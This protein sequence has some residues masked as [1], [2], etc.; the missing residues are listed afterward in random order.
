M[1]TELGKI[2]IL[3]GAVLLCLGVLLTW[4]PASRLGKLPGDLN[5]SILG[6]R[7]YLPLATSVLLS[8][9]LTLLFWLGAWMRK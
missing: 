8:V 5:F 6:V 2:L 3:L 7:V 1:S 4:L 9:A